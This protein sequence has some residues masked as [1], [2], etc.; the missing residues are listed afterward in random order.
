MYVCVSGSKCSFFGKFAMLCFLIIPV[1]RFTLLPY[2]QQNWQ[3]SCAIFH[4]IL[5][6]NFRNCSDA[7]EIE[8]V[9]VQ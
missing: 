2:Y 7:L 6:K 1:L 3:D 4:P 5:R 9:S 8:S